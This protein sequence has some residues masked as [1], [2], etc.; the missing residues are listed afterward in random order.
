MRE[1]SVG[2]RWKRSLRFWVFTRGSVY[3]ATMPS[4]SQCTGGTGA[5]FQFPG[6]KRLN[7][8]SR[9][10]NLIV[11]RKIH[12]FIYQKGRNTSQQK[13]ALKT[14]HDVCG[15]VCV[16]VCVY[17]QAC[18]TFFNLMDCSLPDSVHGISQA[19]ILEWVAISFFR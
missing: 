6:R 9:T 8:W 3:K 1:R 11:R 13:N 10:K 14:K 17:A 7:S 19:R 12:I 15:C 4:S 16:C 2:P 5:V 18:P